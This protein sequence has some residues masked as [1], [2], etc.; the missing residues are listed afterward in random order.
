MVHVRSVVGVMSFKFPAKSIFWVW[1]FLEKRCTRHLSKDQ[2]CKTKSIRL[3]LRGDS[4]IFG[5]SLLRSSSPTLN[6][7]YPIYFQKFE[8][9]FKHYLNLTCVFMWKVH[10]FNLYA[11]INFI[12][13]LYYYK[14]FLLFLQN[15]TQIGQLEHRNIVKVSRCIC[16][17]FSLQNW[18]NFPT[19]PEG[20]FIGL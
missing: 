18:E 17:H 5:N 7:F 2:H 6:L 12:V 11:V 9:Y 10:S 16:S 19:L 20:N 1:C 15:T 14:I 8:Y 4:L 13:M 3:T